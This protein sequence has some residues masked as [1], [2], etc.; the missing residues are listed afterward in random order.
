MKSNKFPI[1]HGAITVFVKD[2]AAL[3]WGI[4]I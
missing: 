2:L 4:P 1:F 3:P